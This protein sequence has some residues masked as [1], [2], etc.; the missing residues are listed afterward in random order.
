MGLLDI[1]FAALGETSDTAYLD[2]SERWFD[3]S[4]K[5]F[6][7]P[8]KGTAV[9]EIKDGMLFKKFVVRFADDFE[10]TLTDEN[11]DGCH[12]DSIYMNASQKKEILRKGYFVLKKYH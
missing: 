9:L 7:E 6:K 5:K 8:Y 1:I 10:I 11:D 4:W 3:K 12:L 2:R